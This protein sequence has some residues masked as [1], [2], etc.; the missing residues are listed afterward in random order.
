[1]QKRINNYILF[2]LLIAVAVVFLFLTN[3]IYNLTLEDAKKN[4]QMQQLEMAKVVSE[5]TRYF[6]YHLVKD[7]ELLTTNAGLADKREKEFN[8]LLEHFRFNYDET[9]ISSIIIINNNSGIRSVSGKAPPQWVYPAIDGLISDT[10]GESGNFRFLVSDV[11]PDD[12][13]DNNSDKAFLIL[14]PVSQSPGSYISFLVNFDSLIR[15]FILPL[16]LNSNDFVWILDGRGRLIYHPRH[17]EMLFNSIFDLQED[18][19]SCHR[20][21]EDQIKVVHSTAPAYG[22]YWVE[23]DEPGKIFAYV[24]LQLENQRWNIAISTLLPDVTQGLQER[25][26]LFF[27][28]GILILLTLLSFVVAIYYLNL[29]R[30]KSEEEKKNLERIRDYQEQLNHSSKLASIG[31]LV[32]SVAHELNTPMGIISAHADSIMLQGQQQPEIKEGLEIIRKQTRRISDYTRTLLNYSKRMPFKPE[33]LELIALIDE[34]LFLLA[35][36]LREKKIKVTNNTYTKRVMMKGDRTQL[37]QVFINIL[38]NAIDA[39]KENGTIKIDASE[40]VKKSLIS[41]GDPIGYVNISISDTGTGIN[42]NDIEKI[43]DPF[44]T[45]KAATGTGLGLSIARSIIQRHKGI[46]E[47]ES[48]EGK[49]TVFSV[50]LPGKIRSL[51][52]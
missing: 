10:S 9:I 2:T 33:E 43:F 50:V 17:K 16:K 35:P 27:I 29:K 26:R 31:E 13:D 6:L 40:K 1:M 23:G 11:F 52:E 46:I 37:E 41:D 48:K 49:W 44:F 51:D 39:V 38:N 5:G 22:E 34:S 4:H 32:D 42:R 20:S 14:I 30:I 8:E 12:A 3:L 15:Y 18:C 47:V 24:P 25:F 19:L 28:L 21:F 7:M 36:R 45:T